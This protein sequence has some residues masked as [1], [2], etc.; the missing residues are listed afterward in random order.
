MRR[1]LSIILYCTLIGLVIS[2]SCSKKSTDPDNNNGDTT[3][4]APPLVLEWIPA[5]GDTGVAATIVIEI[6]IADTG[7][8]A[9]G[10]STEG[11]Q[12]RLGGSRVTP[13]INYNEYNGV[14]LTYYP[15]TFDAAETVGVAVYMRDSVGNESTDS[16]AFYITGLSPDDTCSFSIDSLSPLDG[17]VARSRPTGFTIQGLYFESIIGGYVNL[18]SS[19]PYSLAFTPMRSWI[20][21]DWNDIISVVNPEL[22][23]EVPL[24]DGSDGERYPAL[25]YDGRTLAFTSGDNV[26]FK[27]LFDNTEE[28]F[29]SD[30]GRQLEFS[31]DS[32]Y[33][34][35]IS[36]VSWNP[37]L[38][39]WVIEDR[40]NIAHSSLYMDVD[41]YDW[42]PGR[43]EIAVI[44]D[45]DLYYW[46]I[47]SGSPVALYSS[48][49]IEQVN[50]SPTGD[51]IYFV[52]RRASGD[53]VMVVSL[54]GVFEEIVN[55]GA[56]NI[57]AM[58]VSND[59][60]TLVL[61]CFDGSSYTIRK[62]SVPSGD[63]STVTDE[64]GQT[65]QLRWY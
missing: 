54:S 47:H 34:A 11:L 46:N 16:I 27:N 22:G 48:L 32:S 60:G 64:L 39:L 63:I 26:V 25:N 55:L 57:E 12:M 61:A 6:A 8:S 20:L 17:F 35:Y 36:E 33:L 52:D 42:G 38:Y 5:D 45:D 15:S 51:N 18:S 44:S 29:C 3:D 30:A 65:I 4:I 1:V 53:V 37:R 7:E 31:P 58:A 49:N 14:D 10:V 62:L 28:I 24:T 21:T 23:L 13:N 59:G 40:T 41:D 50:F 9:S 2:I 19:S 43:A 56:V